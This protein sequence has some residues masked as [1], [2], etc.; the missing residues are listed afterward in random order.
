MDRLITAKSKKELFGVKE[1]FSLHYD[2]D[3]ITVY[4]LSKLEL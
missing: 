4:S 1:M 3:Y 2:T